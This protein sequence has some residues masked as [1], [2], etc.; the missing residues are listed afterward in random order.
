MLGS[1]HEAH[2]EEDAKVWVLKSSLLNRLCCLEQ[3]LV[4]YSLTTDQAI[5]LISAVRLACFRSGTLS[6]EVQRCLGGLV[7]RIS[8]GWS[9]D[10][11]WRAY[12][13]NFQNPKHLK[14][15]RNPENAG[16]SQGSGLEE[17]EGQET[18][19]LRFAILEVLGEVVGCQ[20][21]ALSCIEPQ[22]VQAAFW[23]ALSQAQVTAGSVG[24]KV[25]EQG[26]GWSTE[27]KVQ[28]LEFK[29]AETL[30]HL[31][32]ARHLLLSVDGCVETGDRGA[33]EQSDAIG[34]LRSQEAGGQS[35]HQA[36][37]GTAPADRGRRAVLGLVAAYSM[38]RLPEIWGSEDSVRSYIDKDLLSCLHAKGFSSLEAFLHDHLRDVVLFIAKECETLS[39]AE[40]PDSAAGMPEGDRGLQLFFHSRALLWLTKHVGHPYVGNTP[41]LIRAAARML[42]EHDEQSK[43]T[44]AEMMRHFI[45]Q[46]DRQDLRWNQEFIL[47]SLE[48]ALYCHENDVL[49]HALPA[50][51]EAAVTIDGT[52]GDYRIPMKAFR[53]ILS[54]GMSETKIPNKLIYCECLITLV[55]HLA[56]QVTGELFRAV[57][58]AGELLQVRQEKAVSVAFYL[59]SLLAR[60]CWPRIHAHMAD[61]LQIALQAVLEH[62]NQAYVSSLVTEVRKLCAC[63]S[64]ANPVLFEELVAEARSMPELAPVFLSEK[65]SIFVSS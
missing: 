65:E 35:P 64:Q 37:P 1:D 18:E 31:K 54:D 52:S 22:T 24:L 55:E 51:A 11:V 34:Q 39:K 20:H 9:G 7:R 16:D 13:A 26:M 33:E 3:L 4:T 44:G 27:H 41:E 29:A 61:I 60:T 28:W 45:R 63:L 25:R 6:G 62:S 43:V 14:D 21:P 42:S 23:V 59:L 8:Q 49:A 2:L 32:V 17:D 46:A 57:A 38:V 47:H 40:I 12:T 30:A 19:R 56:V 36:D 48:N 10:E 53:R 50:L 5:R 15:P 58:L